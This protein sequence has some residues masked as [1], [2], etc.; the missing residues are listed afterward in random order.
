MST[1]ISRRAPFTAD[2]RRIA[3][4]RQFCRACHRDKT[5]PSFSPGET[6]CRKCVRDE[7]EVSDPKPVSRRRL[8]ACCAEMRA[9]CFFE[10]K[11]RV[12]AE[13]CSL[14]TSNP[15]AHI[16]LQQLDAGTLAVRVLRQVAAAR[17]DAILG[18]PTLGVS[19]LQDLAQKA[20]DAI[21]KARIS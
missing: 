15:D 5:G 13:C 14:C 2:A 20:L 11:D 3:P 9:L 10:K 16:T 1:L 8:C 21:E 7:V 18:V 17:L 4:K 12:T 6:R 19:A